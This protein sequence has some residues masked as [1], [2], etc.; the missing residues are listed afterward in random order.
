[1]ILYL[2]YIRKVFF[3]GT[4][5]SSTAFFTVYR[6]RGFYT[7][8]ACLGR[9]LKKRNFLVWTWYFPFVCENPFYP[10]QQIKKHIYEI[11]FLER[12]LATIVSALGYSTNII[13]AAFVF[14]HF[15]SNSREG[16]FKLLS[17]GFDSKESILQVYVDCCCQYDDPIPTRFL[18][19][20][21][22]YK[23]PALSFEF[24]RQKLLAGK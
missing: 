22:C 19:S 13:L 5:K 21:D 7:I 23:I 1:M 12:G 14:V 15:V 18:A 11:C 8:Q 20:I 2:F 10:F 16:I 9:K 17:P 3:E 6:I 4:S 24:Y